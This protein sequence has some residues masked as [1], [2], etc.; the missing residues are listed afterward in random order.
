MR[1]FDILFTLM[2]FGCTPKP[3]PPALTAVAPTSFDAVQGTELTFIAEG[4]L[5]MA[6]LDFDKPANSSMPAPVV[7]AFV[8]D[9]D[10]RVDV[11][12]AQWV[13]ST[14]VTG[15]LAG[16]V[17]V[18][19]YDVHLIEPRG[20]ELVL[21][22][23]LEAL[24]CNAGDCPLED[25]GLPDSGV[26]ACET[27]SYR[28][29]D[30][31]G[32]GTGIAQMLCG[33]G[34]V[35]L[36]GDCEDFDPLTFPNAPEVCNGLDDDCDGAADEGCG[37]G[38]W[39]AVDELRSNN[40]DF[41]VAHSYE[42]G[43]LWIAG[44]SQVFIR[45]DVLGFVDA[46]SSCPS[47]LVSLWAEP[48]GAVEIGGGL[49]GDGHLV[50]QPSSTSTSC[51]NERRVDAGVPVAMVGFANGATFDYVGVLSDGRLLRW[52]RGEIPIVV[53]SNLLST[54]E[55]HDLHGVSAD[56]LI[57][58]GSGLTG[59]NRRPRAWTLQTDGGWHGE[60]L[61]GLS[62]PNG[63]MLGVWALTAEE[64]IAVGENGRVFRRGVGGWRII[65][66]ETESD[67]TSVRAFSTGRFYVTTEDGLVRQRSGSNWRTVFRN[68]AGVRFNDIT[69]TS[70]N[71]LWVVGNDGV[72]GTT[73]RQ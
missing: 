51:G 19:V 29:R 72:I 26:V 15:R 14:R 46:S 44:G 61:T 73:S 57:A 1:S 41:V 24:D 39:H 40:N 27:M 16:P 34:W 70:E 20:S 31:D 63:T 13:D 5:P 62:N 21:N 59:M 60:S 38:G 32:Y 55:V 50:E 69:A 7:S 65:N 58:V 25:G 4:L 37:D 11:L 10:A 35:P 18:G 43:K 9:G 22:G 30:L 67:L 45:K 49:Q 47:N 28:D 36:N 71:D 48:G 23:A 68:D 3:A 64:A 56:R 53:P 42:P 6:T 54:D 66:A 12:D 52:R 17:N 33:P 8:I 2:I